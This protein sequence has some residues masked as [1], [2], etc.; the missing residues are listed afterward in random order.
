MTLNDCLN[1]SKVVTKPTTRA[2]KH[3][4]SPAKLG[5]SYEKNRPEQGGRRCK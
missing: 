2:T 4:L 3:R 5:Q 1:D